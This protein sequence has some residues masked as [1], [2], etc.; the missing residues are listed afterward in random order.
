MRLPTVGKL[1]KHAAVHVEGISF[2]ISYS[3]KPNL[4][5]FDLMGKIS[6]GPYPNIDLMLCSVEM[7]TEQCSEHQ[8]CLTAPLIILPY[9]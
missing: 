3:V 2:Y 4:L 7:N 1:W 5:E 9:N 6:D 8:C